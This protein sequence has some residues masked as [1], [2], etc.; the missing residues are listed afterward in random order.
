MGL[1]GCNAAI[2]VGS[3]GNHRFLLKV[4]PARLRLKSKQGKKPIS[5]VLAAARNIDSPVYR[6]HRFPR[7]Q[8]KEVHGEYGFLVF[9]ENDQIIHSLQ[10]LLFFFLRSLVET[11]CQ[12]CGEDRSRKFGRAIKN[13]SGMKHWSAGDTNQSS[14]G[15]SGGGSQSQ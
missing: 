15:W 6:D 13:R 8:S 5:F 9:Y 12:A 7:V 2:C 10:F 3:N 11:Q 14:V 4:P 1:G